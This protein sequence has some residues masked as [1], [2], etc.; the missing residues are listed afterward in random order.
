MATLLLIDDYLS[1]SRLS[2][3]R[4]VIGLH[5][6]HCWQN[7]N[8]QQYWQRFSYCDEREISVSA[9][10]MYREGCMSGGDTAF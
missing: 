6:V 9:M 3:I 10:S 4:I 5:V 1:Q 8:I 7:A 2:P